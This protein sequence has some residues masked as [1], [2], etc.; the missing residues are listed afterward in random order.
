MPYVLGLVVLTLQGLCVW[1]IFSNGRERYWVFVVMGLPVA[2][3]IAYVVA[4]IL[5]GAASSRQA[6]QAVVGLQDVVDP[7]RTYRRLH[8]DARLV[9]SAES[10]RALADECA[11][12]GNYDEAI[13]HYRSAM[14]GIH[15]EDPGLSF[16]LSNALL[17]AG[18][19]S[20]VVVELKRLEKMDARYKPLDRQLMNARALEGLGEAKLA[21]KEYRAVMNIHPGPE[22]KVRFAHLLYT[23]GRAEEAREL[24]Q[25]IV[26]LSKR[27]PAHAR[28][29]NKYWIDQ[30]R[31]ALDQLKAG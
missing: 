11:R 29:L 13:E 23:Q 25:G 28:R 1:H 31:T 22:A 5:P 14:T 16:S 18:Q 6:K 3:C 8:E 26:D 27:L 9:D 24:L 12:K 21:E 2:G 17:E 20:E 19:L 7:G 15:L 4:E 30:A 10:K